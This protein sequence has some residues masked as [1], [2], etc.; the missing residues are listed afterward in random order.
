MFNDSS[1]RL[2]F[3]GKEFASFAYSLR[4]SESQQVRL[5]PGGRGNGQ[6]LKS[7]ILQNVFLRTGSSNSFIN[8]IV[9]SH[10]TFDVCI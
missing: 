1:K 10:R 9:N 3:E 5:I 6:F 4:T 2:F 7:Q 8:E